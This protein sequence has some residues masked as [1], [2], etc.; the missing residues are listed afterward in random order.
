MPRQ[1]A[2]E[3]A[4]PEGCAQGKD[5]VSVARRLLDRATNTGRLGADDSRAHV[6]KVKAI[7]AELRWLTYELKLAGLIP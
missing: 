4:L 7:N 1:D 3:H 2:A 5:P 6:E